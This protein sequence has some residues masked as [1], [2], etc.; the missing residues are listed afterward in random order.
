MKLAEIVWMLKK[1]RHLMKAAAFDLLI[2]IYTDY[3]VALKIIKQTSLITSFINKLNFRFIRVFDYLQRF[4]LN[5][6][7]KF[8]KQHIIFNAF[9]R[10]IS[11]NIDFALR[12]FIDEKK[13]NVL[14]CTLTKSLT[15]NEFLTDNTFLANEKSFAKNDKFVLFIIS[16]IEM[17]SDF[18][19]RIL[20]DYKFNLNWQR[21]SDVLKI[22]NNDDE[23]VVKLSFY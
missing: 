12:K 19:Q 4:N 15:N 6:R 14:T 17:N 13:F 11:D 23:N 9:S 8:D 2:V 21:I 18:K 20:K 1:I 22:N 16:L 7:H 10:L 5:I 3:D